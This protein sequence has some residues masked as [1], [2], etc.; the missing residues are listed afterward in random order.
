MRVGSLDSVNGSH[1]SPFNISIYEEDNPTTFL[2]VTAV[3]FLS[4][5]VLELKT[6]A[7]RGDTRYRMVV[8][9]VSAY[10]GTTA[11]TPLRKLFKGYNLKAVAHKAAAGQADLNGD[12]KVDFTDFTIFSS[13]YGTSYLN[14]E[15]GGSVSG[16][17]LDPS[18][19]S[20]VPHTQ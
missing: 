1:S 14:A 9:G 15:G 12:G 19:D 10:D 17:P 11:S 5:N 3:R 8:E 4:N 20:T 18:P 13:V 7:Q 2:P 6:E 16:S